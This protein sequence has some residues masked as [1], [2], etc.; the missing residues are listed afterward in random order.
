MLST[1]QKQSVCLVANGLKSR[2]PEAVIVRQLLSLGFSQEN[3]SEAFHLIKNGIQRGVNAA[4]MNGLPT[5]QFKRGEC[6]MYD[7]AF[8]EGYTAFMKQM[9]KTWL[10]RLLIITAIIFGLMG[11]YWIAKN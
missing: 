11:F 8:D 1:K 9:R 2:L 7:A 5:P 6:E 10:R 3:A 4:L